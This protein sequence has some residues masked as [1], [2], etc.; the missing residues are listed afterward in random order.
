MASSPSMQHIARSKL[1]LISDLLN[2]EKTK[3]REPD[4]LPSRRRCCEDTKGK[5]EMVVHVACTGDG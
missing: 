3:R 5:T 4:C 2:G 1:V